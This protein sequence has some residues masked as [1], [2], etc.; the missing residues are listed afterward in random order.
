MQ[1]DPRGMRA[2][3]GYTLVPERDLEELV[4]HLESIDARIRADN[5]MHGGVDHIRQHLANVII[6]MW[7]YNG[8]SAE[9][10]MFIFADVL[11]EL[12]KQK[13]DETPEPRGYNK[14]METEMRFKVDDD[15]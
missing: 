9:S 12:T 5:S 8:K 15:F 4:R 11:Q 13:L 14:R 7:H 3:Q 10:I 1:R 6:E 2:P